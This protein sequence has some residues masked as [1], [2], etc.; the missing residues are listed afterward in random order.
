MSRRRN[1]FTDYT[2]EPGKGNLKKKKRPE[3]GAPSSYKTE[4]NSVL[5]RMDTVFFLSSQQTGVSK[6]AHM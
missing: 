4:E 1:A 5:L 3:I 2:S 6:A